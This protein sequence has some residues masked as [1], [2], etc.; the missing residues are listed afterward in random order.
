VHQ[1]GTYNATSNPNGFISYGNL[2]QN[3]NSHEAGSIDSHYTHY[4]AAQGLAS[5]NV[6]VG[7]ESAVKLNGSE[8]NFDSYVAQQVNPRTGPILTSTQVEPCGGN[9]E[10]DSDAACRFEGNI[11]Y[12]PYQSCP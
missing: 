11:N 2:L 3:T 6:G 4:T 1:C 5:N 12:F 8:A 10:K 7:I 9:V